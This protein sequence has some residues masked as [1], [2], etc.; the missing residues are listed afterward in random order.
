MFDPDLQAWVDEAA[1][2]CVDAREMFDGRELTRSESL[3]W[4]LVNFEA[5]LTRARV[6]REQARRWGEVHEEYDK[7]VLADEAAV[8]SLC[9]QLIDIE[10]AQPGDFGPQRFADRLVRGLLAARGDRDFDIAN[11]WAYRKEKKWLALRESAWERAVRH[12]R[13]AGLL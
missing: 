9:E 1:E 13:R 2:S 6:E 3:C 10:V 7:S 11:G 4:S 12:A 5:S 8:I